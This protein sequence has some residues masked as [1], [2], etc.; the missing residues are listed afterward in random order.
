[1]ITMRP[2]RTRGVIAG[3]SL[4][5]TASLVAACSAGVST[6]HASGKSVSWAQGQAEA[7]NG[8]PPT[9]TAAGVCGSDSATYLSEL[10]NGGNPL[11][12]KVL[13]EWSDIVPGGKQ[14]LIS[15][16]V[17]TTHLG[18]YD[19]PISH[20]Y[21]YDL[22]MDVASDPQFLA[23]SKQLGT[24]AEAADHMHVEIS[25]GLIP[26]V[27]RTSQ[28]S[29]TQTW[30]Q[31]A[32]FNLQGFQPGFAMP[33]VGDRILIMGRWII[34]CGH[35]NY[36]TELHPMSFL[37]WTHTQGATTVDHT[38]Y[39]PY[40]DTEAYSTVTSVLGKVDDAGRFA[41]A[42]AFPPY[43][44]AQV[45]AAVNGTIDHLSAPELVK[46][47]HTSPV[48]WQV[49][50]PSGTS[51]SNLQVHYDI[52]TRPGVQVTVTPETSAPC[53]TVSTVLGP[54]YRALDA[55]LRQCVL[56]WSY[57]SQVA[58]ATYGTSVDLRGLIEKFVSAPSARAI[59]DRD[60]STTC[61]DAL[62]GPGVT[63]APSGQQ[64][65]VD[66]GQALPFYGVITVKLS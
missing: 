42:K 17:S 3:A 49:C 4:L 11:Q 43:L 48:P 13:H 12:A 56:P 47:T 36:G 2:L 22:S 44:V 18:P 16:S 55:Q 63:S 37:S 28:A 45:L 51:G 20:P 26:H 58:Q 52:V 6:L 46:A 1:M 57:L 65:R 64:I 38:Y 35:S 29:S 5:A 59:V 21:G 61:A 8:T 53:A 32:A 19:L 15:G 34:D 66:A 60:P 9:Y 10:V 33:A 54:N 14:V 41:G 7:A 62:A 50:A 40:Q 27:A 30:D 23:F 24:P 31:L 25:S 39:N